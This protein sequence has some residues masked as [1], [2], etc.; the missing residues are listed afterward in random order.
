VT[1]GSSY[2]TLRMISGATGLAALA[3]L[4]WPAPERDLVSAME[5]SA[6]SRQS[7]SRVALPG[8]RLRVHFRLDRLPA[9]KAPA[10]VVVA[11]PAVE[12]DPAAA[13]RRYRLLGVTI[14]EDDAV[15]LITDG[16][17]QVLLKEGESLANFVATEIRP[18]EVVF[19]S[20]GVVATLS[21]P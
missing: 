19:D 13:L 4:L 16:A 3:I 8:E 1:S 5:L 6:D 20:D 10:P 21:L 2:S 14:N 11:A 17:R 7:A 9:P 15:A 18:R 12:I